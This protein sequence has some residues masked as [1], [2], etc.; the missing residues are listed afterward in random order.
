MVYDR[1]TRDERRW[2]FLSWDIK[3][4]KL[5]S[6]KNRYASDREEDFQQVEEVVVT[7]IFNKPKEFYRGCDNYI[8]RRDQNSL[9]SEF[10]SDISEFRS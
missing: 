1:F 4:R 10:D 2:S 5:L 8:S 7:G 9:F 6:Q 3:N